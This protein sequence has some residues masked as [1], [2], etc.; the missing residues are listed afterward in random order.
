MN[1]ITN[2][3]EY[4][5]ANNLPDNDIIGYYIEDYN[6]FSFH[7]IDKEYILDRRKGVRENNDS[8]V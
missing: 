4:E 6:F 5:G 1:N 2:P 7:S 3:F 8:F